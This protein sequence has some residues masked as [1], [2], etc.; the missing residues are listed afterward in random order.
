MKENEE[1]E[2][3][4]SGKAAAAALLLA[5]VVL[6][7]FAILLVVLF[8]RSCALRRASRGPGHSVA[9]GGPVQYNPP[10]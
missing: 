2:R 8:E 3:L 5:A 7:A 10:P 9:S 1:K 4:R 6:P